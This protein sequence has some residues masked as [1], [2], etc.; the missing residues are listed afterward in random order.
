M[1]EN[2]AQITRWWIAAS[3]ICNE[4]NVPMLSL[5]SQYHMTYG[6]YSWNKISNL[7]NIAPLGTEIP[8]C[9]S[10]PTPLLPTKFHSPRSSHTAYS[11]SSNSSTTTFPPMSSTPESPHTMI[12]PSSYNITAPYTI[13]ST[14]LGN[15]FPHSPL[16]RDDVVVPIN[17][18]DQPPSQTTTNALLPDP[19]SQLT[20]TSSI[21]KKQLTQQPITSWM[22]HRLFIH[23]IPTQTST[24]DHSTPTP[25]HPR[26][27]FNRH[28]QPFGTTT[29]TIDTT[30]ILRICIQNP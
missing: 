25:Q 12:G 13:Y 6:D 9:Q 22:I 1:N 7:S 2:M 28:L 8:D 18:H 26:E 29:P 21:N 17:A 19:K 27:S 23:G 14:H 11:K 30:T 3:I 10:L 4:V 16:Q 15:N 5:T 20:D 24:Q